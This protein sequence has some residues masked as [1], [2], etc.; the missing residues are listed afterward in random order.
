VL[1]GIAAIL[2]RQGRWQEATEQ[3]AKLLEIDPRNP[4]AL[5]AY[6]QTCMLLRRYAEADR[7]LGLS[8]SLS[9]QFGNAWGFRVWNAVLWTG[10]VEKAH[11]ILTEAGQVVGLQD[12]AARVAWASFRVAL[13]RRDFQGALRQLEG[14]APAAL[15]NQFFYLPV[16]LLRAEAQ[17][18]SGRRD[19]ASLSFETARRRLEER[20]S[21]EPDDSRYQGALGIACAGL[22]LRKEALGAATRGA[23]LTPVAKDAWRSLQRLEDLA[24]VH[25]MLGEQNEAIEVLDDLLARAGD[26]LSVHV[27]RLDPRW[28]SLR[29][30]PR[31]E[32]LLVKYGDK[33]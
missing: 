27:L 3:Q 20:I 17:A 21:R 19:L 16:D 32:A 11:S 28:D 1:Y 10:D 23:A 5:F 6:G 30:S 25:A 24:L 22:G 14:R 7:A 26:P 12:E 8:A 15:A 9:P 33:T 4:E 18:L 29:S 2:R 13:I 31:F